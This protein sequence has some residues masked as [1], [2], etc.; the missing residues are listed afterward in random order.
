MNCLRYWRPWLPLIAMPESTFAAERPAEGHFVQFYL[1]EAYLAGTVSEFLVEG[2][3]SGEVCIALSTREHIEMIEKILS[4]SFDL[5]ALAAA[6]QWIKVEM[7]DAESWLCVDGM[8]TD[9]ALRSRLE[10]ILA[11][12]ANAGVKTRIFEEIVAVLSEKCMLDESFE[13]EKIW[14]SI[15]E[16]YDFT[17]FCA[18]STDALR[19]CDAHDFPEMVS[20]EHTSVVPDET[21]TDLDSDGKR[22]RKRAFLEMRNAELKAEIAEFTGRSPKTQRSDEG[23]V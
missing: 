17:L 21:Y 1:S 14:N 11:E 23:L 13:L 5:D 20:S 2:L 9:D 15:Q 4:T 12:A 18:Y 3:K 19:G 7:D 8:P 6:R 16:E 10:P 22:L